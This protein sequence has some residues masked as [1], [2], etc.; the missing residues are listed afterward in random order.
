M[1]LFLPRKTN[2]EYIMRKY[3]GYCFSGAR[4]RSHDLTKVLTDNPS[5]RLIF[6]TFVSFLLVM[7]LDQGVV[8]V[9]CGGFV[10]ARREMSGLKGED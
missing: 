5:L 6:G 9:C 1:W 2:K 4:V 7:V 10:V 8:R 3:L